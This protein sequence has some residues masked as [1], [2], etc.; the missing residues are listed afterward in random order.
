MAYAKQIDNYGDTNWYLVD[1]KPYR[2]P[3]CNSRKIGKAILGYPTEEDFYNENI[4]LIGCLPDFPV[5]RTWGC[6]NC[7]AAFFKDN[8]F[9]RGRLDMVAH[10]DKNGKLR[11]GYPPSIPQEE[12]SF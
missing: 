12:I 4:F 5:C 10:R 1:R 11:L 7:D 9:N 3:S 6:R 8:K 2:C